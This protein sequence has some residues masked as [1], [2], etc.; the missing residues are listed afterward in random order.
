MFFLNEYQWLGFDLHWPFDQSPTEGFFDGFRPQKQTLDWQRIETYQLHLYLVKQNEFAYFNMLEK[1]LGE[2][3]EVP[4]AVRIV[5]QYFAFTSNHHIVDFRSLHFPLFLS[6]KNGMHHSTFHQYGTN[7]FIMKQ[8]ALHSFTFKTNTM[9]YTMFF[10]CLL[11]FNVYIK[12]RAYWAFVR[13]FYYVI[14]Y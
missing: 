7:T 2:R 5:T 1:L 6:I 13:H 12:W 14:A 10:S 4:V 11:K 3:L 8:L 9:V